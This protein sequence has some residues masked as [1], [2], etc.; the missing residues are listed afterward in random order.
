M[1]KYIID[2]GY[3]TATLFTPFDP[4]ERFYTL[5]NTC[6]GIR[7]S[8]SHC[9]I[10]NVEDTDC[11]DFERLEFNDDVYIWDELG[12]RK[13]IEPDFFADEDWDDYYAED[14]RY[15]KGETGE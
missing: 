1:K 6:F 11:T 5:A 8:I 4:K 14:C 9:I 12:R 15:V 7:K 2:Y 3:G 13:M 10:R